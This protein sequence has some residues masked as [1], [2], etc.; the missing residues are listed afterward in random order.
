MRKPGRRTRCSARGCATPR[1]PS[2]SSSTTRR[3]PRRGR[4]PAGRGEG[5]LA[6]GRRPGARARA[7]RRQ[8]PARLRDGVVGARRA[9]HFRRGPPLALARGTARR[10]GGGAA[11]T[12][13]AA[14]LRLGGQ[15]LRIA[16]LGRTL[17]PEPGG[18]LCREGAFASR[19]QLLLEGSCGPSVGRYLGCRALG[20]PG[21][22]PARRFRRAAAERDRVG[23]RGRRLSDRRGRGPPGADLGGDRRGEPAL[24][25]DP[26]GRCGREP[27]A[28]RA[29]ARR[30]SGAAGAHTL[31]VVRVLE[32]SPL[33]ARAMPDQLLRLTQISRE[34]ALG[35]GSM[36]FDEADPGALYVLASGEASLD[37]DGGAALR[38]GRATRWASSRRSPG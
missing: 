32:A 3:K 2:R 15:L 7:P 1:T 13:P 35:P 31:K 23:G 29:P 10:G 36:L 25:S 21:P 4:H 27:C 5:T 33:F 26:R 37:S 17:R 22:G 34:V 9:P 14:A 8:G 30:R 11:R 18:L 20:P 6:P 16:G 12:R 28:A 38:R 19:V 24:P